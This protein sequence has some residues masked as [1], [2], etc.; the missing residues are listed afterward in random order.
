MSALPSVCVSDGSSPAR[1]LPVLGARLTSLEINGE[2]VEG[3]DHGCQGWR[4]IISGSGHRHVTVTVSGIH[5]GEPGEARLRTL[6]I[7]GETDACS[8]RL[9]NDQVLRGSFAVRRLSYS[10]QQGEPLLYEVV[11]ES[12]SPLTIG[13]AIK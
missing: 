4:K 8:V 5:L 6:A 7:S 3:S 1:L 12:A 9:G 13:S 2:L 10:E 11:L